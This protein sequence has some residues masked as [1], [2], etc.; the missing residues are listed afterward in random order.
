MIEMHGFGCPTSTDFLSL[1]YTTE[2]AQKEKGTLRPASDRFTRKRTKYP[3]RITTLAFNLIVSISIFLCFTDG[4][5]VSEGHGYS[6]YEDEFLLN[7][8]SF[9]LLDSIWCFFRN[10]ERLQKFNYICLEDDEISE[11]GHTIKLVSA[12]YFE[13]LRLHRQL[14]IFIN[15]RQKLLSNLTKRCNVSLEQPSDSKSYCGF[16][17]DDFFQACAY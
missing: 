7:W 4:T 1:W 2:M 8:D 3:T 17:V 6:S 13:N 5:R 10:V 9:K 11:L 15:L 12:W 14:E 16:V